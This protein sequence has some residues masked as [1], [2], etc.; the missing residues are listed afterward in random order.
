MVEETGDTQVKL[1]GAKG[2]K[3]MTV[4][5][6]KPTLTE[7]CNLNTDEIVKMQLEANLTD[8]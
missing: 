2:G 5:I 4:A 7:P 6:G 8:R 3:Q 1:S